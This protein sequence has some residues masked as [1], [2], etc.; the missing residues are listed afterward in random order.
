MAGAQA[1]SAAGQHRDA[2]LWMET[3]PRWLRLDLPNVTACLLLVS[4]ALCLRYTFKYARFQDYRKSEH[5][6]A[7]PLTFPY[8]IPLLG[9]LPLQYLWRP[10]DF[11][12]NQK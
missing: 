8:F 5:A 6:K 10:K 11:V 2:D 9:S 3:R 4:A 1:A 7:A 12:L